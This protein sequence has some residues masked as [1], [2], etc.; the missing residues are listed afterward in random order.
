MKLSFFQYCDK[1][2]KKCCAKEAVILLPS[3]VEAIEQF[4][5]KKAGKF[6]VQ[7]DGYS[8]MKK[9]CPFLVK[10]KCAVQQVK[11]LSCMAFPVSFSLKKDK[12]T[13]LVAIDCPAAGHL[14]KQYAVLAQNELKKI[15]KRLQE[16]HS[17]LK[18]SFKM[19][20]LEKSK[21]L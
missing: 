4:A 14:T 7:K 9:P 13:W 15:P 18:S 6:A 20:E 19:T 2:K 21:M 11:P 16:V 10:G 5:E 17:A 3:E 8:I 1:C 12:I